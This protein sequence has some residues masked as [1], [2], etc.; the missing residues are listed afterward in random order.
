MNQYPAWKY[1]L[2]LS[3]LFFGT[4][5]ALPNLFGEDPALQVTSARGFAIP[6]TLEATI[7]EALM[8]EKITVKNNERA[9]NRLLYR[10]NSADDQ[11]QASDVIKTALGEQYVVA[12]NLAH[13]TPT[14]LRVL[15]GKPMTLGLDL[16]GGVHFLMQVDMDTARGQQLDRYVDDLRS[17][18]RDERIRYV[19][20]RR[21][22]NGLLALLR[23]VEDRDQAEDIIRTDQSLQGLIVDQMDS[24]EYFG[25]SADGPE[26]E[27]YHAAQP[28]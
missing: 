2:I 1:V 15:G 27:H 7:D 21:E 12:L 20:V 17:A 23:S 22:G 26:A 16:Q 13:A 6:L 5:Y 24:G 25:I 11:L 8:A 4:L 3:I 19:S 10:F 18:L 9:G 28:G 14:W